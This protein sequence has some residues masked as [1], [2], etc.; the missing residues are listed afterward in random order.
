MATIK[1]VVF[2]T[3]QHIKKDGTTNIKI[4]IYHNRETQYIPT[5]H[6]ILPEEMTDAGMVIGPEED[7]IN[8]ELGE[9]LQKYRKSLLKLGSERSKRIS[10]SEL[11]DFIVASSEPDYEF[12]DFHDF[13]MKYI[14][15][16]KK[17]RTAEWLQ[18][19][20]DI[21]MWFSNGRKMD[22]RDITAKTIEQYIR[23]LNTG[24]KSGNPLEPG[25]ISNYLR[26]LRVLYNKCKSHYN[27]EDHD[28]IRIRNKP[29][30]DGAIPAYRRKR[31]A[32]TISDIKRIRDY[33]TKTDRTRIARDTFMIMF[34]LMGININDL[35]K[36]NPPHRDNRLVYNRAKTNTDDNIYNYP[37][38]IRIEP[39]LR[40][41]LDRYS[42]GHFLSDISKRYCNVKNFMR[43]VNEGMDIISKDLGLPKVTTNWARHTW[44]SLARN[45]A[46]ISKS[47]ID[48]CLGHVNNDTKMADIYIDIDYGIFDDCNR[49]VLDLLK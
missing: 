38:S 31:K 3:P 40:H 28:I 33:E 18:R 14:S 16:I 11:K 25:T 27:D 37:L 41:L 32:I 42:N 46:G 10:C 7:L 26:G 22:A 47:D 12:I 39:E 30:R 44:A 8:Y 29:F 17:E 48:F 49:K 35:Y 4:R 6:Y 23:Q 15:R 19:S 34:Y 21:F 43:A 9:I 2:C 5:P 13:S 36:L 45:K 1:P 24:G 20:L